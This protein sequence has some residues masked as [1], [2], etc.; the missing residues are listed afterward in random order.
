MMKPIREVGIVGYGAYIPRYRIRAAEIS[1]VWTMGEDTLHLEEKAVPGLDE[2]T[3][4]IAIEACLF[5]F[6]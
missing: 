2:D 4:T 1:R 6:L 5:W 3:A